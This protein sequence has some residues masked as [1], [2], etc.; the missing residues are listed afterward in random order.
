MTIK[1]IYQKFIAD[2][3]AIY[4]IGEANAITE[5]IFENFLQISRSDI[6]IIGNDYLLNFGE[7]NKLVSKKK[8]H[9]NII[10]LNIV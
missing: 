1:E 6:V 10:A 3:G 7:D 5:I 9:A 8:L 2:L 4:S